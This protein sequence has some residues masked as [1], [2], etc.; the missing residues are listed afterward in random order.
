ML[1]C[2]C[3]SYQPAPAGPM[4][5]GGPFS[6]A[7]AKL[8]NQLSRETATCWLL[9]ALTALCITPVAY[10]LISVTLQIIPFMLHPQLN[11]FGTAQPSGSLDMF[12]ALASIAGSIFGSLVALVPRPSSS[13]GLC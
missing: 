13:S 5:F 8:R 7:L 2:G 1:N 3:M 6:P 11:P 4:T 10:M 12:T 9:I